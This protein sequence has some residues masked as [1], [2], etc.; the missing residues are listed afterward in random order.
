MNP[1][2]FASRFV[3]DSRIDDE[4]SIMNRMSRLRFV[5]SALCAAVSPRGR[6]GAHAARASASGATSQSR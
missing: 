2:K 1:G 3:C 4:S 5:I 6:S